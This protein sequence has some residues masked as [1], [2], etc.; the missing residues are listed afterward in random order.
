MKNQDSIKKPWAHSST[1]IEYMQFSDDKSETIRQFIFC[2]VKNLDHENRVYHA[3]AEDIAAELGVSKNLVWAAVNR[4]KHVKRV[5]NNGE[6]NRIWIVVNDAGNRVYPTDETLSN[7]QAEAEENKNKRCKVKAAITAS[8]TPAVE[9][10]SPQRGDLLST[11]T[12]PAGLPSF[13][14][15]QTIVDH[16]N[17]VTITTAVNAYGGEHVAKYLNW[18]G[19]SKSEIFQM[20]QKQ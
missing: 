14:Q 16:T 19:F 3:S 5:G 20:V 12:N 11:P 6:R 15:M 8:A 9:P 10:Q 17:Q 4:A 13:E 7:V 2:M 18:I 1:V